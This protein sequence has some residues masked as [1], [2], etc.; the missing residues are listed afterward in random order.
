M[1]SKKFFLPSFR[2]SISRATPH[3]VKW[4]NITYILLRVLEAFHARF[5][6]SVKSCETDRKPSSLM[7]DQLLLYVIILFVLKIDAISYTRFK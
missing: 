3:G 7:L 5:P 2:A 6:V 4:E 1:S